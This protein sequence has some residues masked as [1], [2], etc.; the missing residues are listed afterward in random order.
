MIDK[1]ALCLLVILCL[2]GVFAAQLRAQQTPAPTR[3][4]EEPQ[5]Q[6][7][8]EAAM[9]VRQAEALARRLND[10]RLFERGES[11]VYRGETADNAGK[12]SAC[13][14]PIKAN[15]DDCSKDADKV[16]GRLLSTWDFPGEG[17]SGEGHLE[18]VLPCIPYYAEHAW[19]MKPW[20]YPDGS[21]QKAQKVPKKTN[22]P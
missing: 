12:E 8:A 6:T 19:N 3:N 14:E 10:P 7:D 18:L 11:R 16:R 2:T 1:I 15:A 13:G 21:Y 22:I 5:R 17:G 20:P 4:T 9:R